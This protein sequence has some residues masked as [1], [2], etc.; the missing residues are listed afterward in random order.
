MLKDRGNMGKSGCGLRTT[1]A[2]FR[3]R[4]SSLGLF[5]SAQSPYS[6]RLHCHIQKARIPESAT[7]GLFEGWPTIN[8]K[9]CY[10]VGQAGKAGTLVQ[11]HM[12]FLRTWPS[13]HGTE[14]DNTVASELHAP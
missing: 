8:T 11:G 6:L 9:C 10:S 4:L 2:G 12:G 7:H 5:D 1:V 3:S 13:T 14:A